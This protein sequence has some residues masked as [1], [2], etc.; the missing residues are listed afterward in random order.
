[1]ILILFSF[2]DLNLLRTL[3]IDDLP[4]PLSLNIPIP[5]PIPCPPRLTFL[6]GTQNP[7][8]GPNLGP[9]LCYLP[10]PN[11]SDDLLNISSQRRLL[12]VAQTCEPEQI[13]H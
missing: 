2:C 3:A 8:L 1:M 13:R 4:C 10:R 6:W 7:E 5:I 12:S 11:A 9:S